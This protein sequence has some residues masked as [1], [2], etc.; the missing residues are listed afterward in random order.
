M[1][2]Y[3]DNPYLLKR[4]N[5]ALGEIHRQGMVELGKKN[6]I[7]KEAYTQCVKERVKEVLM[8]FPLEP[9]TSIQPQ[10]PYIVPI[11]KLISLRILSSCWKRKMQIYD[12]TLIESLKIRKTWRLIS[13]RRKSECLKLNR[14]RKVDEALK[15]TYVIVYTKKK[16]LSKTRYH[17][18]KVVIVSVLATIHHHACSTRRSE[19]IL[20][21]QWNV[22]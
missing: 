21:P 16:K 7:E 4:I 2:Y 15:G 18:S 9:S 3:I 20:P 5:R 8:S 19:E 22:Q 6:C 17:A 1:G 14:R 11:Q 13:T 10:R 12:P